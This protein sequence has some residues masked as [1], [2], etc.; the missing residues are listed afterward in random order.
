MTRLTSTMQWDV[1]LQ[2]R[3]GFYY[4]AIIVVVMWLIIASQIPGD[5]LY[6][7]HAHDDYG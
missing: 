2:W 5:T 7:A 3:N 4:A 6:L 1:R